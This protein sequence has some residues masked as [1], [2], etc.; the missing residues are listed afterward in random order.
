[1]ENASK[2]LLIAGALLI[3]ILLITIGI[4]IYNSAGGILNQG[5]SALSGQELTMFNQKFT[6][7]E[8]LISGSSLKALQEVVNINNADPDNNPH[9]TLNAPDKINNIGRYNVEMEPDSDGII[10]TINATEKGSGTTNP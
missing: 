4:A 6:A 3:A 7:Y 2:A 10:R 8:G 9:V 1:M 5:K